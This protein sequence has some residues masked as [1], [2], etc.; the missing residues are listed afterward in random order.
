VRGKIIGCS[1]EKG[2]TTLAG[3]G[4][5]IGS[6]AIGVP[7]ESLATARARLVILVMG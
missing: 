2:S 5:L 3:G 4:W 6:A 1:S 7:P